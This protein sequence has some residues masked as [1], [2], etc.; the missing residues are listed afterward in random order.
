MYIA[1]DHLTRHEKGMEIPFYSF[2]GTVNGYVDSEKQEV[3]LTEYI[4]RCILNP[5]ARKVKRADLLHNLSPERLK[6]LKDDE[7]GRVKR[8]V[9]AL[10]IVDNA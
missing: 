3:Y 10:R 4:Q 1:V 5:I 2:A 9:Q 6:K 7:I 8:Y